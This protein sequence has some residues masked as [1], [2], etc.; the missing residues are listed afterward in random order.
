MIDYYQGLISPC[1]LIADPKS[2]VSAYFVCALNKGGIRL[3]DE[4]NAIAILS[5][6]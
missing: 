3:E 2:R 4:G 5:V 1:Y 6:K